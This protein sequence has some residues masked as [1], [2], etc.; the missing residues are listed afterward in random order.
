[1]VEAPRSNL[2]ESDLDAG[3]H[4]DLVAL[5]C[6]EEKVCQACG[7]ATL[8]MHIENTKASFSTRRGAP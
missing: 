8:T 1:M 3:L 2:H 4:P 6:L 5:P 7:S